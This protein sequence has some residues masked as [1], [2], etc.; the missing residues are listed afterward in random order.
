L[1]NLTSLPLAGWLAGLGLVGQSS[2]HCILPTSQ[3]FVWLLGHFDRFAIGW[4]VGWVGLGQSSQR[5]ILPLAS[6]LSGYVGYLAI[7]TGLPLGWA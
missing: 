7:L 6:Y 5:C 4:L 2:Q 3:L 1:A